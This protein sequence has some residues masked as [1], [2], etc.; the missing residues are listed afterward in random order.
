[1]YGDVTNNA[2]INQ[3]VSASTSGVNKIVGGSSGTTS[4]NFALSTMTV[5]GTVSGNAGAAKS[6]ADFKTRS[7]YE[8]GLGWKFGNDVL[9]PWKIDANKNDGYPYLYWENR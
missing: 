9:N 5:I 7:T 1:A 3:T 2:A 4:N 8:T 6:D